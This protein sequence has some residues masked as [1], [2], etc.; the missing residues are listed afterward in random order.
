MIAWYGVTGRGSGKCV[1]ELYTVNAD[2]SYGQMTSRCGVV[3][4]TAFVVRFPK[5]WQHKCKQC[6]RDAK[7]K[8]HLPACANLSVKELR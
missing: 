8:T 6:V 5:P 2:Q 4:S 3:I 1:A 7:D